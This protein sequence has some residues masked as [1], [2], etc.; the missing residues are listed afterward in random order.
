M[1][2]LARNEAVSTIDSLRT[3]MNKWAARLIGN[4]KNTGP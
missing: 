4:P 1:I 3:T 2:V